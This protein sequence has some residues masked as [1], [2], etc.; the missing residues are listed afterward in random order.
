MR[1]PK[2]LSIGEI[3]KSED[4]L[5]IPMYQ[6]PYDWKA[7]RQVSE[8]FDDIKS[9]IEV[10]DDK[11]LFL[12][13]T[14]VD[15]GDG[16]SKAIDLIDGQQRTTTIMIFL[17][18]LREYAKKVL[19][20]SE[21]VDW[22]QDKIVIESPFPGRPQRNKLVASESIHDVFAL[23]CEKN[24]NGEFPTQLPDSKGKLRGVKRQTN[25]LKPVYK[26]LYSQISEY[27]KSDS[28]IKFEKIVDQLLT[29]T[30][31]IWI[32][33]EDRSEAFEIFERTNARGKGLEISDLLK[34]YLFSKEENLEDSNVEEIWKEI[35]SNAGNSILRMLKHF[36]ISKKGYVAKRDLYRKI[37]IYADKVGINIFTNELVD[38]S[39]FFAA[40]HSNVR[41]EYKTWIEQYGNFKKHN[42]YKDELIR[43]CCAFRLFNIT[44][45]VPVVY[46]GL[47]ALETSDNP[48]K[49]TRTY[50]NLL[51]YVEIYHFINNKICNRIGNEVEKTYAD[52]CTMFVKTDNFSE[53]CVKLRQILEK[54]LANSK[55]YE[56]SFSELSY[57]DVNAKQLI[58]YLADY[59]ANA[60]V[61]PG[62][63]IQI[64]DYF[65]KATKSRPNYDIDHILP[66]SLAK[67]TLDDDTVHEIGNLIVI[68]QQ[69]NSILGADDFKIKIDKLSNPSDYA[70][71]IVNVPT[72][73]TEFIRQYGNEESWGENQ[74]KQRTFDLARTSYEVLKNQHKF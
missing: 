65:D 5:I 40:Y 49:A 3:L 11:E 50:I 24:W 46:A 36:W 37:R 62:A 4:Q 12:G 31:V 54:K 25:R 28:I 14:I 72:H 26:V 7:D 52:A 29:R 59:L 30:C 21:L 70:N 58:R 60:G 69:I 18:A 2:K 16:K 41:D 35:T 68:P 73:V 34:N 51:R 42:Q 33:I 48:E 66:Q 63:R 15:S 9:C 22:A 61:R 43:I 10:E 45:L 32:Q 39:R 1:D 67:D 19:E 74:I 8:F 71:K 53:S 13:T 56:G 55:E 17:I 27:C 57:D 23:M 47:R 6:R 38:F 44:Q 20:N 64:Y